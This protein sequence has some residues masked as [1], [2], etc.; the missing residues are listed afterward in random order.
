MSLASTQVNEFLTALGLSQ[1]RQI[2]ADHDIDETALLHLEESHLKELG[3]SLGHRI[4]L[5][6][7]IAEL[8]TR[9]Q[10]PAEQSPPGAAREDADTLPSAAA[11]NETRTDGERRQLTMMFCDLVGSTELS[12]RLD[13]EEVREIM[14]AYQDICAGMVARFDGYLA[15]FL[16][17]GVLA[18]FGYPRAHEDAAE[19][20]VRAAR[21]VIDGVTGLEPRAGHRLSVRIGIATGI[22]VVGRLDAAGSASELSA[23]GDAPNIAAR[24]QN[25]A[26]SNTIVIAESTRALARGAFLY[27][28]LGHVDLKGIPDPVRAWRVAGEVSGSRFE[29]AHS[30]ELGAFVGRDHEVALL[31]GRWEQAVGGEGQAV[32]LCGEAGIGKSRIAEQIRVLLSEVDHVRVR[33]QCSPFHV[34]S[35]LQPVIA[36]LEHAAGLNAGDDGVARL[37]KLEAL[38]RPTTPDPASAVPLFASLLGIPLSEPYAPLQMTA[39]MA[40]RR[41]LEALA[42]QVV[43]LS[44]IKPVYWLIEDAHWVDPTT[45]ELIGLC[46]ERIRDARVFV[47]ITFR[48]EFSPLWG[49]LPHVTALTLNRLARRQCAQLVEYL[50]GGKPLPAEVLDQIVA[51]TDGVPLFIEELT[52]A[53]LEVGLLAEH[54]DRYVL[55]GPLPPLAIPATLQDS[56]MARLDRLSPVK[57]VAQVGSAIGREFSYSLL[58]AVAPMPAGELDQALAQLVAAELVFVRGQPPDATYIFKHALVQDAAYAS[59]LR[60][61]R[62]ELH[63][64]IAKGL[65]ANYPEIAGRRPELVAHHYGAAGSDDRA[66]EYWMRAARQAMA[67]YDFAEAY[68][69]CAEALTLMRKAPLSPERTR[70]E[71]QLLCDQS[72]T[73]IALK[74]PGSADTGRVA[75]EAVKVSA[76]LGDDVLHFRARW[77][78]WMYTGLA[79]SLPA[80]GERADQLVA[81]ADRIGDV[82]LKLQAHH[83]RWTTALLRG[84][85]GVAHQDIEQGLVLYDFERHSGH[86]ALYGAHDPGVCARGTGACALWPA[87]FADRGAQVARDAVRIGV[88]LGHPFSQAVGYYYAGIFAMMN[89][90]AK[91]ARDHG[92]AAARVAAEGRMP[93]PAALGRV[94]GGWA[95]TQMDEIGRGT[96][97]METT[98]RGLLNIKQRAYLAFVGTVIAEAKLRMGR[99]EEALN[100]LDEIQQLVLETHQQMYLPEVHRLRADVL[101][102]LDPRSERIETEYRTALNI[103]KEQ[104]ALALRLRAAVGLASWLADAGRQELGRKILQPVFGEFREGFSTPD[105]Q[106]ARSLLDALAG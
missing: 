24:L 28:D 72:I 7:A 89:G 43:Q 30:A 66:K 33:Y 51:K 80:A 58:A 10:L 49:H 54:D 71:S 92:D 93:F 68:N 34:N 88:E 32:L 102:S 81:M 35:A 61:R 98:F 45:R 31:H 18:Y 47:L 87:G 64:R 5:M 15:K 69:H 82:D 60:S 12:A 3:V 48:P 20:A 8:R 59:L 74:G 57:E 44:R 104:G 65:E 84:Q 103:G 96:D 70:E 23:I 105:L 90:D 29:V 100:L 83:A 2:F 97:Q 6:K 63:A 94:I 37:A 67:R 73:A 13:P 21:A 77:S 53:V 99:L 79:G 86:W 106:K 36:Q 62:Q 22:V 17:D 50:C 55:T 101:R 95:M 85:V 39:D 40:K 38:L 9:H 46:L 11:T 16:G 4:R 78:D 42:D 56:L 91:S 75:E 14:R 76:A 41:T 26:E 19:R 27:T 1:Y 25:L 52:K